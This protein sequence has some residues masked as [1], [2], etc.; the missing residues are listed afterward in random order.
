MYRQIRTLSETMSLIVSKTG[1]CFFFG[2][3]SSGVFGSETDGFGRRDDSSVI[4]YD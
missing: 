3:S 4:S 1:I 2:T